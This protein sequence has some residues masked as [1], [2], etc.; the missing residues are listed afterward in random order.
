MEKNIELEQGPRM[1]YQNNMGVSSLS[2]G[3]F[4]KL[5]QSHQRLLLGAGQGTAVFPLT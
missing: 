3:H 5:L 2:V 4:V 1:N